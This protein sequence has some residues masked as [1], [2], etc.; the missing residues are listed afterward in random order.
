MGRPFI[1]CPYAP[2]D[3]RLQAWGAGIDAAREVM[4]PLVEAAQRQVK[5]WKRYD[6]FDYS[7][8]G[9][10]GWQED[11]AH[12]A[13]MAAVADTHA[14]VGELSQ[15]VN[16]APDVADLLDV[17]RAAQAVDEEWI[18]RGDGRCRWMVRMALHSALG[19]IPQNHD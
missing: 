5:A 7:E 9:A 2:R 11:A 17:A 15:D 14:A 16:A 18:E 10:E 3:P 6:E 8:P 19:K 13:F 4:R 12:A 1:P